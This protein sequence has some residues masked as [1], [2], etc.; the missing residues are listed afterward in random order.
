MKYD[1]KRGCRKHVGFLL[2]LQN[3]DSSS[4]TNEVVPAHLRRFLGTTPSTF[5]KR[6]VVQSLVDLAKEG[7]VVNGPTGGFHVWPGCSGLGTFSQAANAS[8]PLPSACSCDCCLASTSGCAPRGGG[9]PVGGQALGALARCFL[10][11]RY[12]RPIQESW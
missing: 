6:G 3:G 4:C 2:G 5:R 12:S 11:L 10:F 1:L 9:S 7:G 8:R